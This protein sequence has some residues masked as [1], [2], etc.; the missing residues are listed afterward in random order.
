MLSKL[1]GA[2]P[3]T[4]RCASSTR[5]KRVHWRY[6]SCWCEAGIEFSC[7]QPFPACMMNCCASTMCCSRPLILC[8]ATFHLTQLSAPQ[9]HRAALCQA[10][11][12]SIPNSFNAHT[13]R[14]WSSGPSA[15]CLAVQWQ[16]SVCRG[17]G[18]NEQSCQAH[19]Q[20]CMSGASVP[21]VQGLVLGEVWSWLSAKP[22]EPTTS[23][24]RGMPQTQARSFQQLTHPATP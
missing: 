15:R 6:D 5:E 12:E 8:V 21:L 7:I 23:S 4:A 22:P 20:A 18:T 2:T 19:S 24:P 13:R 16:L 1:I 14:M 3:W 11:A 17:S 9:A 10:L